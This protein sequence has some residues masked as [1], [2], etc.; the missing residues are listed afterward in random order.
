M[1]I[2]TPVLVLDNGAHTIKALMHPRKTDPILFRNAIV[3]SKSERRNFVADEWDECRDFGGLTFRVPFERGILNNWDV[4]K[5]VWDRIFSSKGRGLNVD[6]STTPLFMTEPMFNLTNVGEHYDQMI[7]EEYEFASYMRAPGPAMVPYAP[8]IKRNMPEAPEGVLV[9]DAGHSFTH[10]VPLVRGSIAAQGVRRIDVGGKLMT[11]Y[12]KELVSF[13]QWYMMDQTAVMEHAKEQCCYVTTKW[14]H[15]WD[16]ANRSD[17]HNPIVRT[18]VLPDFLP[19]SPNKLGYVRES[20][21]ADQNHR[22]NG[23]NGVAG[24]GPGNLHQNV[25]GSMMA[26][27]GQKQDEEQL[28]YMNNERFVIPEVVFNPS[29]IELNQGGLPEVIVDS[30]MALPQEIQG[31]MWNNIILVGGS[32]KFPGFVERLRSDLRK[33][34]PVEYEPK[35]ILSADPINTIV[36]GSAEALATPSAALQ[37]WFV[38][39]SEYQEHGSNVC[40]RKF[41]TWYFDKETLREELDAQD[42]AADEAGA[43]MA[44]QRLLEEQELMQRESDAMDVV[45]VEA[46]VDDVVTES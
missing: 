27:G 42:E 26:P 18:Y 1:D 31:M 20:S 41:N 43:L 12:L 22:K 9:V 36:T 2:N 45:E 16:I 38:T 3:K 10:V 44:Q 39:K 34:A 24:V 17:R 37:D 14:A 40:R 15:D 21:M 28:L 23:M 32:A 33:F 46:T 11:N 35:V 29:T 6:P 7:F 13:R 19:D 25:D 30:I 4:Q 5:A 8:D